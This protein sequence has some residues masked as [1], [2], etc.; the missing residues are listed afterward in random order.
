MVSVRETAH[1]FHTLS[2]LSY[3]S[4]PYIVHTRYNDRHT[5]LR[6]RQRHG[7]GGKRRVSIQTERSQTKIAKL[8]I[9]QTTRPHTRRGYVCW[10]PSWPFDLNTSTGNLKVSISHYKDTGQVFNGKFELAKKE[11]PTVWLQDS[12]VHENCYANLD[13]RRPTGTGSIKH[14]LDHRTT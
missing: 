7:E 14:I 9:V 1:G 6:R 13:F 8:P 3:L 4:P 2:D 12:N 5:R 11:Y 10:T